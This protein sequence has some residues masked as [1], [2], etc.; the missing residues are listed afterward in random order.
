MDDKQIRTPES[1]DQYIQNGIQKGKRYK[2]IQRRSIVSLATSM[3]LIL[4]F[5]T[6]VRISP[7]FADT[8]K[9]LP[10]MQVIVKMIQG[11]KGLEDAVS[12]DFIHE[13]NKKDTHEGVTLSVD[14]IIVDQ[15]RMI[16]FYSAETAG[17][18]EY[19]R[20]HRIKLLDG[21]GEEIQAGFAYGDP[22]ESE[23][24]QENKKMNGKIVATFAEDVQVPEVV[25]LKVILQDADS[26]S[27]IH[28]EARTLDSEW[29][30]EIPIKEEWYADTRETIE[31]METVEMEKQKIHFEKAVID[32]TLI[33]LHIKYD[34]TNEMQLFRFDDLKLMDDT[35]QVWEPIQNGIISSGEDDDFTLYFQS[36]YFRKPEELYLSGS[37][38]RAI[39][40]DEQEVV[41]DLQDEKLT[42]TPSDRRIQL[43][44]IN[45]EGVDVQFDFAIRMGKQDKDHHY[46]I[47]DSLPV[48]LDQNGERAQNGYSRSDENPLI[49]QNYYTVYNPENTKEIVLKIIDYPNRIQDRFKIKIK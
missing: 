1:I 5:I 25:Q 46:E 36:N 14:R 45:R 33:A 11:D 35:G 42:K 22:L 28:T 37:S 24:L 15:A 2:R 47:F 21:N 13:V 8:I 30:I 40:K 18:H 12:N 48:N 19:L 41:V 34:E 9:T 27:A 7:A 10:G 3:A 49:M 23:N 6:S 16:I 32:P 26:P 39:D 38:I 44:Q 31:I 29:N 20:L 4:L 43:D 17:D